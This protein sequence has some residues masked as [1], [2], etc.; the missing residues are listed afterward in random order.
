M[1]TGIFVYTFNGN[2]KIEDFLKGKPEDLPYYC[3][4]AI[5]HKSEPEKPL[6]EIITDR[7]GQGRWQYNE[8]T[9]Q[10]TQTS[11]H[12]QY[13]LPGSSQGIRKALRKGLQALLVDKHN[14]GEP[15]EGDEMQLLWALDTIHPGHKR[16]L[17]HGLIQVVDTTYPTAMYS[18]YFDSAE[19]AHTY[20]HDTLYAAGHERTAETY[21]WYDGQYEA[22]EW[23]RSGVQTKDGLIKI[24]FREG[25]K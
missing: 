4:F 19:D 12:M 7:R 24:T 17:Y 2:Q 5:A 15:L 23:T 3:R 11:G 9:G 10:Y 1:A 20:L 14:N 18:R 8:T 6:Y 16:E 13:S 22:A 25:D 21:I